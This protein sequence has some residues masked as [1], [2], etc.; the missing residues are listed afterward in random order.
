MKRPGFISWWDYGF[1]EVAVG[2]HPTV[3]DNFQDGIPPAANFHTAKS[4]KEGIAVWIVRLLEGNRKDNNGVAFSSSVITALQKHLG[5]NNSTLI[6]SWMLNPNLSPSQGKPIGIQYDVNLSKTLLVGAQYPENAYYHDIVQLLNNTLT[7]EEITWLYHDIQQATGYSIRY[8][9]V[10]GYDEQI[11]NIFAFLGDESNI[12]TAL[13]TTS[14]Q[15]YNPE[16]DFIQVVYTGYSINQDGSKGPDGQWTAKQLNEMPEAQRN[17]VAVTGTSTVYKAD[18]FNTMF[19]R[20]YVGAPAQQDTNGN[21]QLPSQQIPC[22]AMKHFIPAYVS[23][24][25]YY[26]QGRSAVVIAKYYEGAY[27]NGSISCNNSPLPYV[28]AAVLD[29]Y[30]FPHD[31]V[32]TDQNGTFHLIAPGG[33]ISL[34]FTYAN[35]VFLKTIRFNSTTDLLYSPITDAQA[36]RM[37]GSKYARSFNLSV[38]LSTLEGYVYQ[39]NN[40]NNSYE[41]AVDTPLAGIT[42]QL[43][44]YYFGRTIKPTTTD[45]SGHYIFRNLYTSKYNISAVEGNYTL[46]NKRGINVEPNNNTYNISKPKVAGIKGVV[47]QDT[48]NDKKYTAGEEVSDVLVRLSYTKLDNTQLSVANVTTGASGSF[49]FPSLIPGAYTLNT[50]KVNAT[51]GNLDFLTGQTVTLTANRTSWVNIS[52]TYAP[53]AVSGKTLSNA[54]G[55]PG[56]PITFAPDKTV[57]N[58]TATKQ[59]TATSNTAGAFTASLVPGSYNVTVKKTEGATIVYTFTGK[60]VLYIGQGTASYNISLTKESV[61]V[62]GNT[63]YNGVAKGNVTVVFTKDLNV[64]NNTAVTTSVKVKTT[65]LYTI[66]LTPGSYNV[67]VEE[68]I[69]ESGQNVTYV[70]TGL[71]TVSPGQAPRVYN[72]VLT[73]EIQT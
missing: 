50:S 62:S 47:Y 38:N 51:T 58:N 27:F 63:T 52:L 14:K 64:L 13:R 53:I 17:R 11:F 33:N 16:D 24:F 28:T 22:Y 57:A 29:E 20:A 18:Y 23:P 71:L 7:D 10:E 6:T 46:L 4:E 68:R 72:I 41:P 32:A 45:A 37:N 19:Y 12:L 48:N 35:D 70:S 59:S 39:D 42:V 56:I 40:N 36:M 5:N 9:G 67:T 73:R 44:D 2:G 65:G 30:G 43:D 61:T 3:A 55:I 60:L 1:Y 31:Y 69:N 54:V 15:F 26:Q 21:Y 66:E 8:Y 34:L 25:P 49:A